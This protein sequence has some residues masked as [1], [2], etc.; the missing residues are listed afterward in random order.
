[1]ASYQDWLDNLPMKVNPTGVRIDL[2]AYVYP[3]G[4]GNLFYPGEGGNQ[5]LGSVDE[6]VDAFRDIWE[7][8][9]R[10]SGIPRNADLPGDTEPDVANSRED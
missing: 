6:A 9:S 7:R 5:P 4:H 2:R 3:D 1:M 10:R 8:A